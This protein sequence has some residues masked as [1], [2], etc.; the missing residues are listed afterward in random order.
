[1]ERQVLCRHGLVAQH[2]PVVCKV[3]P[4]AIRKELLIL[5]IAVEQIP[6]V[7]DVRPIT[8]CL[9]ATGISHGDSDAAGL[10]SLS[11]LAQDQPLTSDAFP[12]LVMGGVQDV[13]KGLASLHRQR[14]S[15]SRRSRY[16][17]HPRVPLDGRQADVYHESMLGM[18]S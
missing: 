13:T 2:Y 12:V 8:R 11:G 18:S 1:M 15:K 6:A 7:R 10:T 14:L 3:K 16:L 9:C 5:H 4:V 17:G